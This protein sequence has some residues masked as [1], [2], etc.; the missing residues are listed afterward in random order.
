LRGRLTA[1]EWLNSIDIRAGRCRRRRR[2]SLPPLPALARRL[3]KERV[4][5]RYLDLDSHPSAEAGLGRL[6][7]QIMRRGRR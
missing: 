1:C 5:E 7:E 2:I 6:P 4:I 3:G